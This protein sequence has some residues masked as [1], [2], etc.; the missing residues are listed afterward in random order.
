MHCADVW[1]KTIP[2]EG[3]IGDVLGGNEVYCQT[4]SGRDSIT[5]EAQMA[6]AIAASDESRMSPGPRPTALTTTTTTPASTPATPSTTLSRQAMTRLPPEPSPPVF[7]ASSDSQRRAG[8]GQ[9]GP[10]TGAGRP[11]SSRGSARAAR[12]IRLAGILGL[13][14]DRL[15]HPPD[16][17]ALARASARRGLAQ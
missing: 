9:P 1:F 4:P 3:G 2:D 16:L 7:S 8:S 10:A 13:P 11:S 12:S 14:R 5:E 15:G 6:T 17:A